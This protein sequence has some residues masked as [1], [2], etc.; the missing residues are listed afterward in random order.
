MNINLFKII[1]LCV[2]GTAALSMEETESVHDNDAKAVISPT[3][4]VWVGNSHA[5]DAITKVANKFNALTEQ[6]PQLQSIAAKIAPYLNGVHTFTENTDQKLFLAFVAGSVLS[7]NEYLYLITLPASTYLAERS[8][9]SIADA[10]RYSA[11]EKKSIITINGICLD[12][13]E[14]FVTAGIVAML[15]KRDIYS[16]TFLAGAYSLAYLT[17]DNKEKLFDAGS[18]IAYMILLNALD[19]LNM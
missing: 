12:A 19:N 7:Q 18:F 3:A 13:R 4:K 11:E 10:W 16:A 6:N 9:K 15:L 2:V 14:L 5:D 8:L 17:R 1:C